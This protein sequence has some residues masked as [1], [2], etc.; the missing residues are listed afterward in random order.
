MSIT[1]PKFQG[2]PEATPG[3]ENGFLTRSGFWCPYKP[4]AGYSWFIVGKKSGIAYPDYFLSWKLMP[5]KLR[6]R[7]KK[8]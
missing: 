1:F 7:K 5:E 3:Y 2:D 8:A 6:K 4:P